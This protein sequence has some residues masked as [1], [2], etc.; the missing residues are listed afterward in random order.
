MAKPK[1]P[2]NPIPG[3]AEARK[4]NPAY[5]G[6]I[7]I[8]QSEAGS[9]KVDVRIEDETLWLNL[10]QLASLFQRD[11]S[12]ISRHLKNI[13]EEGELNPDSTVANFATVQ[14]E[15]KRKV[16]REL[17]YYNLDAI[18][19]V[20]YRVKSH[21]ATKFRI[22]ATARLKE[23]LIK[24]FVLDDERLKQARND[25]FDELLRR[26]RD[27]RSSEKVFYRKICDIY[28]TSVDYDSGNAMSQAFFA[29]VQNKFH[30]AIAGKTAAEI[31]KQRADATKPNMGLTNFPAEIVRRQDVTVAKNYLDQNEL[32]ELNLIVS[33]YL[34]FAELQARNRKPMY[35]KDW[36]DKLHGF[37]T[38]N[39]REILGHKGTVSSEDAKQ[40]ALE[41][42]EKYRNMLDQGPDDLD[43]AIRHLKEG[44][45]T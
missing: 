14:Q 10:N 45:D 39:D 23:Y 27:I 35:M 42:Y 30:W 15:G 20:G 36:I 31:V 4:T 5:Q 41:E 2:I 3:E 34:E 40:H 33:Q 29:S 16:L 11:K 43:R 21:V 6:E 26:I 25:Y 24:G 7:L 12:V 37:L 28:T 32:E 19:S 1:Q 13:F 44:D 18:I 17:E 38:L 8:Y 9:T 22:W